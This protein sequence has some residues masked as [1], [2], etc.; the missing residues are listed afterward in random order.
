MT[1]GSKAV[2]GIFLSV[3]CLWSL[4]GHTNDVIRS[5]MG[6][7]DLDFPVS[8][9]GR[10]LSTENALSHFYRQRDYTLAW[11]RP[12][13]RAAL[14]NVIAASERHGLTPSDYHFS[15]LQRMVGL[16]ANGAGAL[17][18]ETLAELDMLLTD[19][20]LLLASHLLHGK[21]NPDSLTPERVTGARGH[22]A[23]QRLAQGLEQQ[24]VEAALQRLAP[25]GPGY[26]RLLLAR[27]SVDALQGATWPAI[28]DGTTIRPGAGDTRL[29]LIRQRLTLLGDHPLPV[30]HS[31]AGSEY[32]S[33]LVSAVKRFQ[34]RHGLDTDGL[35]GTST[36]AA[37]NLTPAERLAQ[38]DANLERWRWLPE[39]STGTQVVVN[40]AGFELRMVQQGEVVFRSRVIVGRPFRPTPLFHDSIRQLVFNPS[41]TVPRSIMIEDQLPVI[42]Q[43]PDY[44]RNSGF[45]LY[46]GWGPDRE[47]VNPD[48]VDWWAL[49]ED[50][51]PFQLIQEP[52]PGN[53]LGQ[54]KFM[55]PNEFDVY[56]HDTPARH[57]FSRSQRSFSSGCIRV[58]DSLELAQRLLA[59]QRGWSAERVNSVLSSRQLTKVYLEDPVPV[60]LEY[61]TSWVDENGAL[62]W[63]DDIYQHNGELIAALATSI[64]AGAGIQ[65]HHASASQ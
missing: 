14:L 18:D 38:I 15:R 52:G 55:F 22:M 50:Y 41:W 20:A 11:T 45:S 39:E 54:V 16:A 64:D 25:S 40:V 49:S 34:A 35:I 8:A 58:E 62:H 47:P 28:A 60:R 42:R 46:R 51:F 19:S 31:S 33:T 4:C 32:D 59:N 23:G 63:R 5:R 1:S 43:N 36:V 37:L 10:M 21:V 29:P 12:A 30:S 13:D 56:L 61:W 24:E 27:D 57:L 44:L 6:A 48:N 26:Q 65:I 17:D 7:I 53:A 9:L 3:I 2:R